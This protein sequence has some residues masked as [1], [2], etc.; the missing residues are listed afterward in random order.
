MSL[1]KNDGIKVSKGRIDS[2]Q[3]PSIQDWLQLQDRTVTI[4]VKD[5]GYP[6]TL[7]S[8]KPDQPCTLLIDSPVLA[9][10]EVGSVVEHSFQLIYPG[11]TFGVDKTYSEEEFEGISP[12]SPFEV[13]SNPPLVVI[14]WSRTIPKEQEA[15]EDVHLAKSC[16]CGCAPKA[17]V[18][19]EDSAPLKFTA[20]TN[21]TRQEKPTA[22]NSVKNS[23]VMLG[24]LMASGLG[25]ITLPTKQTTTVKVKPVD[26]K[27]TVGPGEVCLHKSTLEKDTDGS[28][29]CLDCGAPLEPVPPMA[30]L[31]GIGF[32]ANTGKDLFNAALNGEL[33]EHAPGRHTMTFGK[34]G[35]YTLNQDTTLDRT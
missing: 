2:Q 3:L 6:F 32:K 12:P 20:P 14:H 24:A 4:T 30:D 22:K 25:P 5:S 17:E 33:G 11:E 29:V 7:V 16:G 10:G 8:D 15:P 21:T 27:P 9:Q 34:G 35:D 19:T 1:Y 23:T 18:K 28:K 31:P 26:I 13:V